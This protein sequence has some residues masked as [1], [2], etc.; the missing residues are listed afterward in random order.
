MKKITIDYIKP[1]V[2]FSYERNI[3]M[4]EEHRLCLEEIK[5]MSQL[6]IIEYGLLFRRTG[7]M[8]NREYFQIIDA[9]RDK[10]A[11]YGYSYIKQCCGEYDI[12]KNKKE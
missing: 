1:I 2:K 9:I 6:D 7:K 11:T 5:N 8:A 10:L 3:V 4:T 12:V